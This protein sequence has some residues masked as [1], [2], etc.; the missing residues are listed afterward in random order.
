M[1]PAGMYNKSVTHSAAT[2]TLQTGGDTTYTFASSTVQAS[3][4]PMSPSE[5]LN[6]Q[7]P[8]GSKMA[9]MFISPT[10]T[11]NTKD[12]FIVDGQTYRVVGAPLDVG[13]RGIMQKVLLELVT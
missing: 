2:G 5:V 3:V 1:N 13:G 7:R 11:I 9:N 10:V 6:L 4:Q 8:V 12:Q